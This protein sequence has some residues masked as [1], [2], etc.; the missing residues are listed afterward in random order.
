MEVSNFVMQKHKIYE[1]YN[2]G[3]QKSDSIK[4]INLFHFLSIFTFN[5][6]D[7]LTQE[8]PP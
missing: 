3:V 8:P 7:N 2:W 1:A 5:L 6:T 4:L